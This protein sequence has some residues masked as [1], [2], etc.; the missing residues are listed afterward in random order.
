MASQPAKGTVLIV[1]SNA[2]TL[3]LQGGRTFPTGNYLNET[4]IPMQ[5]LR[6][7]GYD[8]IVATPD[9]SKPQLDERSVVASHFGGSEADLKAAMDFFEGDPAFQSISTLESLAKGGLDTIAGVFVPGGHAPISDLASDP[10]LGVI[11]RHA[12]EQGKPTALLC[13]GPIAL[14]AAL[15]ESK[16][17]EADMIEAKGVTTSPHAA[18]W[19]Y[20]GYRMTIFS[21]SEE[22]PVETNILGGKLLYPVADA[23]TSAGGTVENGPDYGPFVVVDRELITGQNPRSDHE[24]AAKFVAALDARRAQS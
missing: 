10:D 16:Q 23:L 2:T 12:H 22:A 18:D 3:Q 17:F 24:M 8:L 7:A 14:L 19:P 1:G 6:A 4:V 21:N 9:G 11:L 15:T 13:H 5:A 20:R